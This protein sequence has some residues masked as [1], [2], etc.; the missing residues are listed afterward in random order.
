MW[1]NAISEKLGHTEKATWSGT[2]FLLLREVRCVKN[3]LLFH[4]FTEFQ[5]DLKL[6]SARVGKSVI[7]KLVRW[8]VQTQ[9][10]DHLGGEEKQVERTYV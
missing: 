5:S 9:Q 1:T 10:G 3:P 7:S 6:A 2:L 8:T 4:E